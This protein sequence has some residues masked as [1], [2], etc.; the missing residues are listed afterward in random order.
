MKCEAVG[1]TL[2]GRPCFPPRFVSDEWRM[3]QD[4]S[5]Q[6]HIAID[7]VGSRQAVT[8]MPTG[9]LANTADV[10]MVPVVPFFVVDKSIV[11]N[12][13]IKGRLAVFVTAFHLVNGG[14]DAV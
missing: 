10:V 3:G 9:S 5:L 14:V 4:P 6:I 1:A 11:C 13:I 7:V 12:G 8:A 2:C